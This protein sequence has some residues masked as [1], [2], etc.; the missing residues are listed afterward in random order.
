[1]KREI[2]AMLRRE[3]EYISGQQM[4]ERLG[5]SR[6]AVWKTVN[7]LKAEGYEIEAVQNKGYH[8]VLAPD[9]ITEAEIGSLRTDPWREAP[10]LVLTETDS[11]N[12]QARH[13]AEEG[14]PEGTLV[15]ADV[16]RS[17]RG[18]RGRTWE[19]PAGTAIAMSLILRPEL[20]P[21]DAPKLTLLAALAGRTALR[22]TAGV[23]CAVKWPNDL[24]LN[25]KK[26]CGILTEMN[27]EEDY[28]REVIVGIGINVGQ[29]SFPENLRDS[30]TS[31]YRETG[32]HFSRAQILCRLVDVFAGLYEEFGRESSLAF[33]REEYDRALVSRDEEVRIV[34]GREKWTGISLGISDEGALRVRTKEG[35]IREVSAGEVSVRGLYHY[36]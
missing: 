31:L 35:E 17:G 9:V 10:L 32:R 19:T 7:S 26:V 29:E 23:D 30:A 4:C 34:S 5:V 1:M 33:V 14:S 18:R 3:G 25:R 28:I 20:D 2:L 8:L 27:L 16:Q 12:N 22:E 15:A 21:K 24:V 6:T 13:L 36:T 11:T